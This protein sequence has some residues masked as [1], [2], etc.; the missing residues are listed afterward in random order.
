MNAKRKKSHRSSESVPILQDHLSSVYITVVIV[1]LL[2]I[3]IAL[4]VHYHKS[5]PIPTKANPIP[6]QQAEDVSKLVQNRQYSAAFSE[7]NNS[8]DT[9]YT[10]L[11]LNASVYDG[12][13]NYKEA[14]SQ[15]QQAA[16]DNPVSESLAI[17]IAQMAA[18]AKQPQIARDY[19]NQAIAM[20]KKDPVNTYNTQ[21]INALEK[22]LQGVSE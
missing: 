18:L 1:V 4:I 16:K 6:K 10:K 9:T 22:E 13:A 11:V 3:F 17:D 14:L 20:L 15:Y 8:N 5:Q 21:A 19:F 7:I 12:E 2:G